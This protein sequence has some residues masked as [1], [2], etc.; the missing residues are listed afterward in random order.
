MDLAARP[1]LGDS[2]RGQRVLCDFSNVDV[3]L[4]LGAAALVDQAREDFLITD[5]AGILLA[6]TYGRAVSRDGITDL[7]LLASCLPPKA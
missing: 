2:I 4:E 7:V 3:P 1:D 6:G 5:D